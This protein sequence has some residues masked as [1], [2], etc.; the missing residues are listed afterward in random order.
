MNANL[1]RRLMI[2]FGIFALA[3][4]VLMIPFVQNLGI[5]ACSACIVGGLVALADVS[6]RE[7]DGTVKPVPYVGRHRLTNQA[8]SGASEQWAAVLHTWNRRK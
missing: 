6:V 8:A 3:A 4:G 7:L 5:L 2:A 1:A